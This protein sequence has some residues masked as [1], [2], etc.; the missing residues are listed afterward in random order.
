MRLLQD[1]NH[2]AQ[3]L[4][5]RDMDP[6]VVFDSILQ[7]GRTLRQTTEGNFYADVQRVTLGGN[8]ELFC[9]QLPCGGSVYVLQD[10][11]ERVMFDTGFGIYHW[12]IVDM[13]THYGVDCTRLSRIYI[14]HADA[15]H[16]GG[17]GMFDA[18]SV[19]HPGSVDIIRN[20][21]RAYNSK[22]QSS[23]LGEV[24]TKLINLFSH[25][26]PPT[27]MEVLPTAPLRMRGS[28]PVIAEFEAA[29]RRFE[30]L[31]SLGGHLHGQIF[32]LAADDGLLFTGDTLINF[33][34]FTPEREEFSS[35]AA[36]LMTT[37]NVDSELAR[38]ER[39]AL[40]DIVSEIDED[41]KTKGR[42]L[43][44]CCGHGAIS[45][46]EGKKLVA[47][48]KVERYRSDPMHYPMK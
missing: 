3:E 47:H 14:T 29:G 4:T 1:S 42:R 44:L 19:L 16:C 37:V 9:F 31:E 8:A 25:F 40:L 6:R 17:A 33:E 28:L 35:L 43:L 11:N 2:I 13:L 45:T 41:L 12:E 22:M 30:V 18:P 34:S 23:I 26:Q 7:T 15:D 20:A 10:E 32:F 39:K 38:T 36:T 24:Y 46:L 48:G 5:S 27:E 21:N